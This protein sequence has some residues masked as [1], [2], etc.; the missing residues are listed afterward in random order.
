M[1]KL[2]LLGW[3]S[4]FQEQYDTMGKDLLPARVAADY[5]EEYALLTE[6]GAR[7]GWLSGRLRYQAS[8][9][10]DF[11][12]VGDWVAVRPHDG[13]TMTIARIFNRKTQLIR[14]AAGRRT[15]AQVLAANLDTVFIV[16]SMNQ[17]FHVRRL[18]RYLATVFASGARPVIV[19]SKADLTQTPE[20][21]LEEASGVAKG[22]P[23]I[24]VSV[25]SG[26]GLDRLSSFLRPGETVAL[27]GSS[28]VG[29]STLLNWLFGEERQAVRESRAD[30]DKGRH[31][32]TH[33]ELFVLPEG[34]GLIIDTPGIRELQL[35]TGEEA[36]EQTFEDIEALASGCF[37]RN[38]QHQ[39][40][41]GCAVREA[42]EKGE[43]AAERW[44]SFLKL[45]R[46]EAFQSRK[47]DEQAARLEKERYR[48]MGKLQRQI[49][50]EKNKRR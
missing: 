34:K 14:Q 16:S 4:F 46:E 24:A 42:V 12:A 8:S 28:G 18:E 36:L 25:L 5:G 50:K 21:F 7:K 32:T 45:K 48:K 26:L 39:T 10:L 44:Q 17:E 27:V 49:Q 3:S 9:K 11:P 33:R 13:E 15:S 29:K 20:R 31:T 6:E 37:Y 23:V 35:W 2:S 22:A 43:I 19:L 40:E 1:Q 38:C 30:D 41:P 47:V